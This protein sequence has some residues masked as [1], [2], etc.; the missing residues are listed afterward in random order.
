MNIL[1]FTQSRSIDV[2]YQL[3]LR[4]NKKISI[5][6]V[7]FFVANRLHY[8]SFI[9]SN[10]NFEKDFKI[11][12]EWEIYA[13][14]EN[15]VPDINVLK[16]YEKKIGDPVLWTPLVTDRRLYMGKNSTVRQD[17]KPRFTAQQILSI[18]QVGCSRIGLLFEEIK[19]TLVFTLYT[20]TFGDCLAHMFAKAYNIQ[21]LDIRLAR[22]K[23]YI[24]AVDGLSEPP[25][26]TVK[27]HYNFAHNIPVQHQDNAR[28]LIKIVTEKSSM[29]DGV[30]KAGSSNSQSFGNMVKNIIA[31]R[32]LLGLLFSL[33]KSI[34]YYKNE[35]HDLQNPNPLRH[36]YYSNFANKIR[37]YRTFRH[38][39]TSFIRK[40]NLKNLEFIL[41]PLH[42]EPELV[43]SQFA[44]PYLNQIEVIRNIA[45][46]LPVG[47]TLLVKEHPMMVEKRS[48]NFYKKI[49]EIPNAKLL[50]FSLGSEI[51]LNYAKMV[52]IL[53]GAIGLEA[54]MK[55]IPV[56]SLGRS[57][58]DLL[59]PHMFRRVNNL[60]ELPHQIFDLLK[61]YAYDEKELIRYLSS[62][63]AGSVQVNLISD[64]LGKKG[65]FK[66]E[67][68]E[69]NINYN[70]HPH[71]DLL[72]D[73]LLTRIKNN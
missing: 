14:A 15:I 62:V 42:T 24:M 45:L 73:Y 55:R 25:D 4:L 72:T 51:P 70:L 61:N 43:L 31:P 57:M 17:Y 49:L 69:N 35:K 20:A 9:N 38:L 22:L 12:K 71:F 50:D 67:I 11:L 48:L 1:F 5:D 47:M 63:I 36:Y 58:F 52:V 29:Y 32:I 54:V 65:R 34:K 26:H 64:L 46:S 8:H 60:Y 41:Y 21:S 18:L 37:A 68:G 39:K 3:Y 30:V 6:N 13:E 19:P 16:S 53:R 23:N 66:T 10:P 40:E 44:R 27:I 7:G 56:I 2:F 59:P 33:A 28:E